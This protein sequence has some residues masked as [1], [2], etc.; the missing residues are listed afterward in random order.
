MYLV[1]RLRPGHP[2]RPLLS[3]SRVYVY[4]V[5]SGGFGRQKGSSQTKGTQLMRQSACYALL[6]SLRARNESLEDLCTNCAW[7]VVRESMTEGHQGD[8]GAL[9]RLDGSSRDLG[10]P[11]SD[12]R[13]CPVGRF[14]AALGPSRTAS[15]RSFTEQGTTGHLSTHTLHVWNIMPI[16]WGGVR[17]SM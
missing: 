14:G 10:P 11:G 15:Y 8:Q 17:G 6:P 3:N 16:N 4:G 2:F 13:V 5:S 7:R 9:Y 1:L 12:V